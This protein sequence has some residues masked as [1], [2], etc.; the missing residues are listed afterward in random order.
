MS[1]VIDDAFCKATESLL[2]LTKILPKA[3]RESGKLNRSV[4]VS[5]PNNER[6]QTPNPQEVNESLQLLIDVAGTI[7]Q[8]DS[9]EIIDCLNK[10][11]NSETRRLTL[12]IS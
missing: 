1:G 9:S 11:I 6:G 8:S 2:S 4:L 7:N 5:L 12:V 3:S 10:E